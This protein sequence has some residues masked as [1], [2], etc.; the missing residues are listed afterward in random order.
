M[1]YPKRFDYYLGIDQ[2][3]AA[4]RDVPKPLF[5]SIW[6]NRLQKLYTKLKI[7][8]LTLPSIKKLFEELGL[9]ITHS[10]LLICVDTAIGLPK[11]H[12]IKITDLLSRV[13]YF[14][15]SHKHYG[16]QTAFRFYQEILGEQPITS[17]LAESKAG[18]N[19]VFRRYPFQKNIGC[20][21]YRVLK[22]LS[23]DSSWYQIWPFQKKTDVRFTVAEGYPTLLWRQWLKCRTRD[24]KFLTQYLKVN[25]IA[26]KIT[27][28]LDEA[29]SIVLTLGAKH[30]VETQDSL[31]I[32]IS[33]AQRSY[34]GWILGL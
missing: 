21:S 29:D 9:D 16:A 10:Q 5:V 11:A 13:K 3:G 12:S 34:E 23:Q 1:S 17:R 33:L 26:Q 25:K 6:D 32:S 18:A 28:S 7:S 14:Q 30:F 24:V 15:Y 19:S 31:N 8:S 22:D 4:V 27:L 2:T 20:G